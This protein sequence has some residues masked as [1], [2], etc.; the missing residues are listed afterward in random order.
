MNKTFKTLTLALATGSIALTLAA[1]GNTDS[2]TEKNANSV[3]ASDS[4]AQ[5][6]ITIKHAF[7]ETTIKD[8]PQRIASV[9]WGEP[10][11]PT[12]T[13]ASARRHEQSHLWR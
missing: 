13:G 6:P 11:S 5:F 4:N 12:C 1:C 10:R 3:S 9:G 7:G 8:A 2:A